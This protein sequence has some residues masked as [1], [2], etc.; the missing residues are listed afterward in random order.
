MAFAADCS[1]KTRDPTEPHP[2]RRMSTQMVDRC[3][4]ILFLLVLAGAPIIGVL[5]RLRLLC[6]T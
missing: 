1:R 3:F 2:E 4:L 5:V 6:S